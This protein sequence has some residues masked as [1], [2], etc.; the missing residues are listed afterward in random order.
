[1]KHELSSERVRYSTKNTYLFIE[2]RDVN[3]WFN[4]GGRRRTKFQL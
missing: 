2:S 4:L 3:K 1:M